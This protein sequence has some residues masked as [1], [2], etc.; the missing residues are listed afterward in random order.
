MKGDINGGLIL[1][2]PSIEEEA[3]LTEG[4]NEFEPVTEMAEQEFM[5]LDYGAEHKGMRCQ[6]STT[7]RSI[8]CTSCKGRYQQAKS[9]RA[10]STA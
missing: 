2:E 5:S 1:L 9:N 8:S 3:K 6:R 7:S 4:L 10:L